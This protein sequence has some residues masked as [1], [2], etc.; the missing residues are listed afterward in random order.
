MKRVGWVKEC[1]YFEEL[2]SSYHEIISDKN[3]KNVRV[4]LPENMFLSDSSDVGQSVSYLNE[5]QMTSEGSRKGI[6]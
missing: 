4:L 6:K 1:N 3:T 2:S 5:S